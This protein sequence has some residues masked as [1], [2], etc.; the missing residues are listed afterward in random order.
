MYSL[1]DVPFSVTRSGKITKDITFNNLVSPTTNNV[2]LLLAEAA[3]WIRVK[4][5][6]GLVYFHFLPAGIPISCVIRKPE[7]TTCEI[8]STGNNW[9]GD[10]IPAEV[11]TNLY[12][13][14]N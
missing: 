3:T 9:Q 13:F 10:T 8:L 6:D 7:F 12:W 5:S 4:G 14:G 1:L 2:L 11:V